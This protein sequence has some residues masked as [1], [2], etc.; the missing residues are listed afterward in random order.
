MK[1]FVT[2]PKAA[3]VYDFLRRA[4]PSPFPALLVA[5]GLKPGQLV[6][7]LRHLRGA[8]YA[9]P[10]RYRGVEFWCLNG[11]RPTREQE[12]LAWFAARLEEA[13]GRFEHGTAYFPKGRAVPVLV[14][15]AQ[16][17]AGELFCF[18]EDLR[19]KPLKECV[20]QKQKRSG[21]Y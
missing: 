7:A 18:L 5:L 19:E 13:G 16:V 9:F 3:K 8:G 21:R 20:R 10:A 1:G 15:G 6:K 2:S 12:A 4:G 11:T 17:E 14:D